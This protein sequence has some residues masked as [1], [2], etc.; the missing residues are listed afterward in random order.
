MT[1]RIR[2]KLEQRT[3]SVEE[4]LK[5]VPVHRVSAL[6][7]QSCTAAP[8][9]GFWSARGLVCVCLQESSRVFDLSVNFRKSH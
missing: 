4:K 6:E 1:K 5:F 7:T 8:K 9:T 3:F 2:Q